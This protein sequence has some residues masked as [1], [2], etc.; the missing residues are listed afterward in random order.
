MEKLTLGKAKQ[1]VH[2]FQSRDNKEKYS[3]SIAYLENKMIKDGKNLAFLSSTN[4]KAC[5]L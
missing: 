1:T 5:S 3:L 4:L 2:W